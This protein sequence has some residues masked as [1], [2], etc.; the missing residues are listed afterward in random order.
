MTA[1]ASLD[2]EWGCE[3]KSESELNFLSVSESEGGLSSEFERER[4]LRNQCGAHECESA[5]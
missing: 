5:I 2:S 4:R 1:R 3:S